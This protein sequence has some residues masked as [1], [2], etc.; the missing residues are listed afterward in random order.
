MLC[1]DCN[2]L[3]MQEPAVGICVD[4]GAGVRRDHAVVRRRGSEPGSLLERQLADAPRTVSC[5]LFDREP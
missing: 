3:Q 2:L 1:L 5:S 4:C